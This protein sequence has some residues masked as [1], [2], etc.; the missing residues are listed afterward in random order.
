[1][2]SAAAG[3]AVGVALAWVVPWQLALLTGWDA[4][5]VVVLLRVWLR[6]GRFSA[7]ETKEFATLEDDSRAS[8]DLLILTASMASLA[9]AAFGLFDV[10]DQLLQAALGLAVDCPCPSGCPSCV[11][12][13]VDESPQMKASALMLLRRLA[14]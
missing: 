8:A 3:L 12:P 11:G 10:H 6:V 1:M 4:V 9:G 2:E 5:A 13:T 7:D 14:I